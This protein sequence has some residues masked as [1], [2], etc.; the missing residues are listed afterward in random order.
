ML[1]KL[2]IRDEDLEKRFSRDVLIKYQQLSFAVT[3]AEF[4]IIAC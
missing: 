4:I 1:D 3:I 2:Y